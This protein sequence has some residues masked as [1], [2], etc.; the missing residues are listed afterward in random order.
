[1]FNLT[2]K[3]V[4]C[5][6]KDKSRA[7]KDGAKVSY[8]FI[9]NIAGQPRGSHKDVCGMAFNGVTDILK[10]AHKVK[11][12]SGLTEKQQAS[13]W[14]GVDWRTQSGGHGFSVPFSRKA[15][16]DPLPTLPCYRIVTSSSS[17]TFP[18][19]WPKDLSDT[20]AITMLYHASYT[21]PAGDCTA[22]AG[23]FLCKLVKS[24]VYFLFCAGES[25]P[26]RVFFCF[27]SL[28]HSRR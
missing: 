22:Y 18:F 19:G 6:I 12:F 21:P 23:A 5:T 17:E 3:Q 24:L 27:D 10:E 14:I 16:S 8:H 28:N 20:A 9:F 2:K 15:L 4:R 1:M 13:P 26:K 7:S 11:S 25:N